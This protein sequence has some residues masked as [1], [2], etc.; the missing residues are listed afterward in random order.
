MQQPTS[1]GCTMNALS[2][3]KL[4]FRYQFN[5]PVASMTSKLL[6]ALLVGISPA[7]AQE[8]ER[9]SKSLV[10]ARVTDREN[11]PIA[12]AEAYK[13]DWFG[14]S[15]DNPGPALTDAQGVFESQIDPTAPLYSNY[16]VI[17]RHGFGFGAL[18][19][20]VLPAR[21]RL[22]PGR[23][24]AFRILDPQG[25]NVKDARVMP[26]EVAFDD[27]PVLAMVPQ[28]LAQKVSAV[29]RDDGWATL[30]SMRPSTLRTILVEAEGYGTQ[31]FSCNFEDEAKYH[32]LQLQETKAIEISLLKDEVPAT[33]WKVICGGS[34]DEHFGAKKSPEDVIAAVGSIHTRYPDATGRVVLEH[35]LADKDIELMLFDDT[36]KYRG[37]AIIKWESVGQRPT[38]V[39]VPR[40]LEEVG[41]A[42]HCQVVDA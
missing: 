30:R 1:G 8:R 25:R 18:G 33:G 21:A 23:S 17:Y 13:L 39:Q 31:V 29:T 3:S 7:V 28:A 37:K 38:V 41:Q 35:A 42:K 26:G 40:S 19:L 12:G 36:K 16:V 15:K 14:D 2:A 34:E 9:D 20:D 32:K 10:T 22:H 6:L 5:S 4:T 11:T 24:I 27:E